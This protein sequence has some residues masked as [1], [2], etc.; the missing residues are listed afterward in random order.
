MLAIKNL[1]LILSVAGLA[2]VYPGCKHHWHQMCC[3]ADY[4]FI[5]PITT[6]EDRPLLFRQGLANCTLRCA[7]QLYGC[8]P[9][10]QSILRKSHRYRY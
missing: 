3:I 8:R 4:D 2:M 1:I 10:P 5:I 9:T 6:C 7:P